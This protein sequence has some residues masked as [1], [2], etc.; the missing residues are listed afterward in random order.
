[1]AF[2]TAPGHP[3]LPAELLTI[4]A[5]DAISAIAKMIDYAGSRLVDE[6]DFNFIEKLLTV[7]VA[8]APHS[9]NPDV[10]L[11]HVNPLDALGHPLP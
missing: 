11:R 10:D 2:T 7:A 1:M 6:T 5:D 8:T 4:P 3:P 9:S